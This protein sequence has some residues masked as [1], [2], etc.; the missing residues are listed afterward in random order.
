METAEGRLEQIGL[1]YQPPTAAES[2]NPQ[3]AFETREPKRARLQAQFSAHATMAS[4]YL[5]LAEFSRD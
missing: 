3:R 2:K 4:N 5:K 1:T